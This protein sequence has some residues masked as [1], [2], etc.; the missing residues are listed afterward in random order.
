M[1][2]LNKGKASKATP[3]PLLLVKDHKDKEENRDYP[4]QLLIPAMNFMAVFENRLSWDKEMSDLKEKLEKLNLRRDEVTLMSLDIKNMYPLVWLR[5]ILK[6][7]KYY[8][9][10]LLEEDMR[11]IDTCLEMIKFG[12]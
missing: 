4:M 5:L 6:A 9:H 1:E 2:F 8:G 10:N 11:M 12:M 7:L 3:Q